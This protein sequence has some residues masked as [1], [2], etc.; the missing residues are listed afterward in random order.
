MIAPS[1]RMMLP[2]PAAAQK[3]HS[4]MIAGGAIAKTR[5]GRVPTRRVVGVAQ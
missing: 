2:N 4:W 1:A 3:K 5:A